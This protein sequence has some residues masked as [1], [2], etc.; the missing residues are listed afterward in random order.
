MYL[1]WFQQGKLPLHDLITRRYTLA[2]INE[3][4]YD[5]AHGK[6]LGRSIVEF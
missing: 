6:I 4:V 2:Q 5:L 1:D 3:A